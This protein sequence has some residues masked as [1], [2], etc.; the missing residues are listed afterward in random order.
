[1]TIWRAMGE[2]L[3]LMIVSAILVMVIKGLIH[4]PVIIF[5]LLTIA[6]YFYGGAA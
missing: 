4:R 6:I 1:M 2:A 3:L 5:I